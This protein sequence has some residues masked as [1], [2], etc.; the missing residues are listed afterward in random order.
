MKRPPKYRTAG[1]RP[2]LQQKASSG[3][4]ATKQ[5]EEQQREKRTEH[6]E[7]NYEFEE[8]EIKSIRNSTTPRGE[9]SYKYSVSH[10]LPNLAGWRT[11]A[12]CRYN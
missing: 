3:H 11:A 1:Y 4:L 7:K 12:P 9:E 5:D 6:T 2:L 10:W 8:G